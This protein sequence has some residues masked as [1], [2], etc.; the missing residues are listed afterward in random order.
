MRL[1]SNLIAASLL[2]ACLL[3]GGAATAQTIHIPV[4]DIVLK[5]GETTEF[6]QVW[7]V[8]RD[9][10]SMMT[11]TPQ[12]EVLEGPPGVT[13]EMRPAPVVP[14]AVSCANPI[15]GGKLFI[16]ARG[17]EDYSRSTMVLRIIYKTRDGD[18]QRA[19]H[20]SVTLFP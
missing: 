8:S 4:R 14:R 20:I 7:L 12:V 10:K 15:A 18:R 16:A 9:C 1:S 2:S 17:V 11:A 5:N 3:S 19:E 6:A 13:V